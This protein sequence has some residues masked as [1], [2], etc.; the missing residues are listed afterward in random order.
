M[1]HD[2]AYRSNEGL[3]GVRKAQCSRDSA[4]LESEVIVTYLL[5]IGVVNKRCASYHSTW[6]SRKQI[7]TWYSTVHDGPWR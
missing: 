2:L 7:S 1:S 5:S 4:T 3:P 6:T